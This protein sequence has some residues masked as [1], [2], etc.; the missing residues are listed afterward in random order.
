MI[1][2]VSYFVCIMNK[3]EFLAN[4]YKIS[5]E[6]IINIFYDL[7]CIL[8]TNKKLSQAFLKEY[9]KLLQKRH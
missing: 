8:S 1:A 2:N 3:L 5:Q 6:D 4:K 9:K 7:D